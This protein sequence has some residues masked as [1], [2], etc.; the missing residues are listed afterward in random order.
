MVKDQ[1]TRA[2]DRLVQEYLSLGDSAAIRVRELKKTSS[3]D[4]RRKLV[5]ELLDYLTR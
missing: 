2:I 1:V 5:V 4:L 3:A